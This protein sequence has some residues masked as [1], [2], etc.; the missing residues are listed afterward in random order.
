[1][2]AVNEKMYGITKMSEFLLATIKSNVDI[3][4]MGKE[5][6]QGMWSEELQ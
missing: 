5:C 3:F 4:G 1:M 2:L 6:I